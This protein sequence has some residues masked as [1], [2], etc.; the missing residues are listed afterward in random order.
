M[1]GACLPPLERNAGVIRRGGRPLEEA[2][3]LAVVVL[4]EPAFPAVVRVAVPAALEVRGERVVG[5]PV[6]VDRGHER[7]VVPAVGA[8]QPAEEVVERAV[9]H[10]QE[11]AEIWRNL[12]RESI[13]RR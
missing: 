5:R 12:R 10:H 11:A 8:G 13:R 6:A 7:Q 1:G 2:V 3:H 9:L 4:D